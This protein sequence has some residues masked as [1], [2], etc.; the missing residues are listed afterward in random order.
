MIGNQHYITIEL[1]GTWKQAIFSAFLGCIRQ[2]L[3]RN[4]TN[5]I[6]DFKIK[7]EKISNKLDKTSKKIC[8]T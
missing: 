2:K 4:Y 6:I 8:L 3:E 7:S 5:I 1:V